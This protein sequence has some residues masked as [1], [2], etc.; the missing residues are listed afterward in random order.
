MI[1]VMTKEDIPAVQALQCG[2]EWSFDGDFIGGWVV[3]EAGRIVT[4]SGFWGRAEGHM[5]T[6]HTWA[7]PQERLQALSDLH[8]YVK[9]KLKRAGIYEVWTFMDDMRGFGNKLKALGWQV[10]EKTVWGRRTDG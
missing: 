9:P 10:I 5:V 7:T 4:A 3:E 2:Y 6:D 8:E 1:R